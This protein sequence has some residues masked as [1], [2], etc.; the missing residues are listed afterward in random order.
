M[1]HHDVIFAREE[2]LVDTTEPKA[3]QPQEGI[4]LL[5]LQMQTGQEKWQCW[6]ASFTEGV[7]SWCCWMEKRCRAGSACP[8]PNRIE[9]NNCWFKLNQWRKLKYGVR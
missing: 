4:G 3:E 7:D 6:A 9:S 5:R 8:S 2:E 1:M